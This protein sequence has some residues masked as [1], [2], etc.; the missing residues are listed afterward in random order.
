MTKKAMI[1]FLSSDTGLSKKDVTAV[2]EALPKAIQTALVA[3]E[4]VVL[5]N[6]ASFKLQHKDARMGRNPQTG[7][8]LEIKARKNVKIQ[9]IGTLQ[10][11][12]SALPA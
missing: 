8:A 2:L 10:V 1:D 3:D 4:R 5:P 7:A 6:V 9:A 11:A 12:I